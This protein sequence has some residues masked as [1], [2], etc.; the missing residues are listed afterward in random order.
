MNQFPRTRPEAI[1]KIFAGRDH[2]LEVI[3]PLVAHQAVDDKQ[4]DC[5]VGGDASIRIRFHFEALRAGPLI[6]EDESLRMN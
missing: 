1:Q 3:R 2:H 6:D 5:L 4:A